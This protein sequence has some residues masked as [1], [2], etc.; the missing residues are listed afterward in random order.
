MQQKFCGSVSPLR[1]AISV[2]NQLK[3]PTIVAQLSNQIEESQ[4]DCRTAVLGV[5][6]AIRLL[7]RQ[8]L[9]LRGNDED[10]NLRELWQYTSVS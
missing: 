3:E 5:I 1:L 2:Y 6:H 9:A 7:E 8:G 4:A 10:G